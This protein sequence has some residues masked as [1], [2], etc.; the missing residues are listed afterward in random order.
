[1]KILVTGGA[2]YIGS[3]TVVALYEAGHAPVIV[4]DFRNSDKS[5]IDGIARIIGERPAAYEGDCTDAVFMSSVFEREK[6]IDGVIHFAADKAVGESV[7]KPLKYY[8]N[9]LLSLISVLEAMGKYGVRNIIFSSS[10]TVYGNPESC[11]ISES[12]PLQEATSPYGDTKKICE[13]ILRSTVKS[14]SFPLKAVSLRYFN[15]IGAHQSG[16]IG[17]QPRGVPNNLVPYLVQ[18]AS[19]ERDELTVHGDDYPTKDGTGV[20]DYIH[21]LDLAEAHIAALDYLAKDQDDAFY[22]F[23]NVGTGSGSSVLE[24]IEEF[25]KVNAMKVPYKTGPRRDGDIAA[26]YA[27]AGK[28]RK[29]IGWSAKRSIGEALRDAWRWENNPR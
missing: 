15:P 17:E 9:N 28:I 26:C 19:G 25:E 1:M 24:L 21:V 13:N 27:D 18:A 4:D 5:A 23:F 12:F 3:H 2:G 16:L 11:P 29:I 7:A 14:G 6:G 8:R 10:A 20:R 22:D